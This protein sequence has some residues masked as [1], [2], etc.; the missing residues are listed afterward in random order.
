MLE[1]LEWALEPIDSSNN[2]A[3]KQ[4]PIYGHHCWNIRDTHQHTLVGEVFETSG[5]WAAWCRHRLGIYAPTRWH[6]C[7]QPDQSLVFTVDLHWRW[8]RATVQDA[9]QRQVGQVLIEPPA[10][11]LLHFPLAGKWQSHFQLTANGWQMPI[12]TF[13]PLRCEQPITWEYTDNAPSQQ[14]SRILR[15]GILRLPTELQHQF[16]FKMLVLAGAVIWVCCQHRYCSQ[17]NKRR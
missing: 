2:R 12:I 9:L 6:F 16:L 4:S 10:N 3:R 13:G 7:E 5:T 1:S 11:M 17:S 8:Q 14:R 15:S